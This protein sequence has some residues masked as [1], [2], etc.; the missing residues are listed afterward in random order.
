[1]QAEV[2]PDGKQFALAVDNGVQDIWTEANGGASATRLTFGG[3]HI[4]SSPVWSPD[5]QKIAYSDRDALYRVSSTGGARQSM[6]QAPPGTTFFEPAGWSNDGEILCLLVA[7]NGVDSIA[8]LPAVG[9]GKLRPIATVRNMTIAELELSPDG[10]WVTYLAGAP[11]QAENVYMVPFHGDSG[12]VWQAT[13][14]GAVR[15]FWVKGGRELDIIKESGQLLAFLVTVSGGA[16]VLGAAQIVADHFPDAIAAAPDG[17]RF[18]AVTYPDDQQ[19]LR[20]L[21]GRNH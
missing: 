3:E 20:I 6:G 10:R 8:A 12:S 4:H 7:A 14:N 17:Q 5:G 21:T 15:F 18:L 19:R 1:M 13:D 16:P 9:G 11:G 2:S